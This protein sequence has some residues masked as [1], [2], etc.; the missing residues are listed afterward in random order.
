MNI[1]S[2]VK[3]N[4]DVMIS[5]EKNISSSF[6]YCHL[7]IIFFIYYLDR[8]TCVLMIQNDTNEMNGKGT[9]KKNKKTHYDILNFSEISFFHIYSDSIEC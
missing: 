1:N 4:F 9:R 8:F 7:H 3:R 6:V 5:S 2:M